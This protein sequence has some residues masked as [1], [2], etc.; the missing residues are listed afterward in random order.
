MPGP[1]MNAI[2]NM[3][4]QMNP[5]VANSPQA[6]E[7]LNVIRSGDAQRGQQIAANLCRNNNVTPEQGYQSAAQWAQQMFSGNGGNKR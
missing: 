2:I 1:N 5:Q 7:W 4:C 6:Q 3:L